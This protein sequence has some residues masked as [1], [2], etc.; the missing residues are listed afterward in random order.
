MNATLRKLAASIGLVFADGTQAQTLIG[1]DFI[2]ENTNDKLSLNIDLSGNLQA[3]NKGLLCYYEA[4][5]LLLQHEQLQS[6]RIGEKDLV[7]TLAQE[8]KPDVPLELILTLGSDKIFSYPVTA[9]ISDRAIMLNVQQVA[10][11]VSNLAGN[12]SSP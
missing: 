4:Q 9:D 5:G 11:A 7:K 2:L 10:A 12:R 6:L 3:R 1:T 8:L